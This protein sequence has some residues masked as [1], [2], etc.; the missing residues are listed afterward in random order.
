[1]LDLLIH[2]QTNNNS[3]VYFSQWILYFPHKFSNFM[4]HCLQQVTEQ[5]TLDTLSIK[6][7]VLYQH[8]YK[9][10]TLKIIQVSTEYL[11]VHTSHSIFFCS[12]VVLACN[13]VSVTAIMRR[14]WAG[15]IIYMIINVA[16]NLVGLSN[17]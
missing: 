2:N 7:H 13:L 5:W 4:L 1:M 11:Q 17:K 14:I 15:S 16:C 6:R 8:G 3:Y 9:P 12:S 10:T